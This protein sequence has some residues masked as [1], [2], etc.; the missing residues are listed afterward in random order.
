MSA[1][2]MF[3]DKQGHVQHPSVVHY[4]RLK[5]QAVD[6]VGFE[7][8]FFIALAACFIDLVDHKQL[9]Q[10]AR[11]QLLSQILTLHYHLFPQQKVIKRGL[12]TPFER[13]KTL[14]DSHKTT[15]F[16]L[17]NSLAFTFRQMAVDEIMQNPIEYRGLVA[18]ANSE[19]DFNHWRQ[20]N[21][22]L[23]Q[24]A[25]VAMATVFAMPIRVRET[26]IDKPLF[27]GVK[28]ND[29]KVNMLNPG[30]DMVCDSRQAKYSAKVVN[31]KVFTQLASINNPIDEE[32]I[33][34]AVARA[35]VPAEDVRTQLKQQDATLKGRYRQTMERLQQ[36][37]ADKVITREQLI[38]FYIKQVGN[39]NSDKV[40]RD[41]IN[42]VFDQYY[43]EKNEVVS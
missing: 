20:A 2:T 33:K 31:H 8:S 27:N 4:A 15:M 23:G 25:V 43:F 28:Y 19:Y 1:V 12:E 14:I 26:Q 21:I 38:D 34:R 5:R 7:D 42:Q 22:D 17:V 16:A 11:G 37:L 13:I 39:I 40:C 9:S 6:I 29:T 30:I 35:I 32:V 3:Q 41:Y 36:A 24:T 18:D 10:S